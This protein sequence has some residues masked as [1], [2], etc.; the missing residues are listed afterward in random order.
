MELTLLS[1]RLMQGAHKADA[2]KL[3]VGE[4]ELPAGAEVRLAFL[5]P[6]G[7]RCETSAL[8]LTDGEVDYALPS[9]LLDASGLLL[10]QAV[11]GTE[12][13]VFK[14]EVFA[15]DVE[16]S[17]DASGAPAPGETFYTLGGLAARLN[18]KADLADLA[19]VATSGSYNDLTDRPAIPTKTSDLTN[20]SGFLTSSDLSGIQETLTFDDAPTSGSANP[21]KS[22]GVY[23]ALA[24]KQDTL[25]FDNSPTENSNNLIKSG[26]LYN[27]LASYATKA[28]VDEAVAGIGEPDL[29]GF[30]K[31][32]DLAAVAFSGD[33]D[34]LTDTPT[35][36]TVPEISTNI[37]SDASSDT[38][39]ASPKAVKTYV[40]G[41]IPTVREL[42]TSSDYYNNRNSDTKT[43]TPKGA[44]VLVDYRRSKSSTI[45]Q[46]ISSDDQLVTPK[47]MK[48]WVDAQSFAASGSIPTVPTISTDISSDASSDAKTASPKA[49]KTYVDAAIPTVPTISTD[50]SSDASS[51]VK[52]ASPKAVKTYVDAA[53]PTVPTI[54]TDISSD[55]SSDVK[56]A[57]PKAVKTYVDSAAYDAETDALGKRVL[58]EATLNLSTMAITSITG[59]VNNVSGALA[60]IN[61]GRIVELVLTDSADADQKFHIPYRWYKKTVTTGPIITQTRHVLHFSGTVRFNPTGGSG[62]KDYVLDVSW[63]SIGN[64]M[65]PTLTE[66][67]PVL[68]VDS[69]PASGSGNPVSS[70][71]VHTALANYATTAYADGKDQSYVVNCDLNLAT[72]EVT[73]LT[74][75][76]VSCTFA[77]AMAAVTA[78]K[79]PEIWLSFTS[80]FNVPC[81]AVA[82]MRLF[83]STLIEFSCPLETSF[84]AGDRPYLIVG[85]WYSNGS[86]TI[87]PIQLGY[88]SN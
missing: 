13:C 75:G 12:T 40:D 74:H 48:T 50:I 8:T 56:T 11:A 67:P 31:T 85:Y 55:A 15:F 20:D 36:P 58:V 80:I 17:I 5:T 14:S 59:D 46:D 34:D 21:V 71:G 19:A 4:N 57:S 22:G 23:T 37:S 47:A 66:I 39:T 25:S 9:S 26:K 33:Y 6:A 24:G 7:R 81:T 77:D 27:T 79:T 87:T 73:N 64:G 18:E 65:T 45:M 54:S 3:S 84:G 72:L 83:N 44:S 88:G 62:A 86:V 43:I 51:D 52:T 16:K 41:A 32:E 82:R 78:G 63:N 2:L 61:E 53:I 68:T 42:V 28:Y 69:A 35:I 38:K 1:A 49:V 70:G 29:T 10:A 60:C 30:A 76:G